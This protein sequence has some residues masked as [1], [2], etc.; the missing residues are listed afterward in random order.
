MARRAIGAPPLNRPF[1]NMHG[2]SGATGTSRA[3]IVC[4]VAVRKHG[5]Y[6][7]VG[8]SVRTH[9]VT[10]LRTHTFR[11]MAGCYL[12]VVTPTGG[13]FVARYAPGTV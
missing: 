3:R 11:G 6:N 1:S 10:G 2:V 5:R 8:G 12:H 7:Q 4:R 9:Y 13:Q